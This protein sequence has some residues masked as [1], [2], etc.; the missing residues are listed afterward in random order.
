M[1]Y[2]RICKNPDCNIVFSTTIHNQE[3]CSYNCRRTTERK[4]QRDMYAKLTK[5]YKCKECGEYFFSK[6]WSAT[7]GEKCASNRWKRL[8]Q[9]KM[10]EKC[11]YYNSSDVVPCNYFFETGKL[12]NNKDYYPCK[13]FEPKRGVILDE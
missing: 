3:Y 10:C 9:L 11:K 1:V 13:E 8:K 7:C 6:T 2:K 4:K 5:M 12:R